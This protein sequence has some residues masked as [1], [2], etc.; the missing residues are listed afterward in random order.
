MEWSSWYIGTNISKEP[1]QLHSILSQQTIIL[2]LTITRTSNLSEYVLK[3]LYSI[4]CLEK[5]VLGFNYAG[6]FYYTR[7]YTCRVW[8]CQLQYSRLNTAQWENFLLIILNLQAVVSGSYTRFLLVSHIQK[9]CI[10]Y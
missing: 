4:K 8:G 1:I 2:I 6:E 9:F 7:L 5:H 10:K 3:Q